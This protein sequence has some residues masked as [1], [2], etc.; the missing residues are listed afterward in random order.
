MANF[1]KRLRTVNLAALWE[2]LESP[3]ILQLPE[4]FASIGVNAIRF[5]VMG[6]E[7]ADGNSN[8]IGDRL[9]K[10]NYGIDSTDFIFNQ[11]DKLIERYKVIGQRFFNKG[12]V[13]Y[14][15]LHQFYK[16][17][18]ESTPN[19][20]LLTNATAQDRFVEYWERVAAGLKDFPFFAGI[21][22]LNEPNI[23]K[24][25]G[26]TGFKQ[27]EKLTTR[28]VQAI[29]KIDAVT[30]IMISASRDDIRTLPK[31]VPMVQN[32]IWYTGHAYFTPST[33]MWKMTDL[34]LVVWLKNQLQP[35]REWQQKYN[36]KNI[37][38]GECGINLWDTARK[39]FICGPTEPMTQ[40]YRYCT[41]IMTVCKTWKWHY[42]CWLDAHDYFGPH[43]QN[44]QQSFF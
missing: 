30:P 32:N 26:A 37:N 7:P 17:Q 4:H 2:N 15:D 8:Y 25:A 18:K 9:W 19:M 6:M 44:L 42:A 35:V 5:W 13:S 22:L 23:S 39:E 28:T 27:W 1:N 24:E 43:Q 41:A 20:E 38:V 21:D 14:I 11:A 31:L 40:Y 12:I 16:Q 34:Q 36:V 29:R 33:P 10:E 3:F